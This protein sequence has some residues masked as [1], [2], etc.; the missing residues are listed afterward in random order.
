MSS[1]KGKLKLKKKAPAKENKP[2]ESLETIL[3]TAQACQ[4]QL[5]FENAAKLYYKALELDPNNYAV[6]DELGEI[7]IALDECEVAKQV[8]H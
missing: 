4:D 1:K 7:L 5:E 8:R 6:M 2:L 3:Q